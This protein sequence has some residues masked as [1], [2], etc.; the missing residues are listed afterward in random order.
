MYPALI[1]LFKLCPFSMTI[2]ILV[3]SALSRC[4]QYQYIIHVNKIF[5]GMIHS[6]VNCL[7]IYEDFI[8]CIFVLPSHSL[9]WDTDIFLATVYCSCSAS[10]CL[11]LLSRSVVEIPPHLGNWSNIVVGLFVIPPACL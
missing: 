1:L 4:Q 2:T 8:W 5:Y 3:I 11:F 7:L 6:L 9:W 10:G